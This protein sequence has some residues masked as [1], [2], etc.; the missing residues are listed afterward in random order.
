MSSPWDLQRVLE[1]DDEQS[2]PAEKNQS[3]SMQN[4]VDGTHAARTTSRLPG[5]MLIYKGHSVREYEFVAVS[6]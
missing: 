4:A 6:P 5:L 1:V 2:F 3:I